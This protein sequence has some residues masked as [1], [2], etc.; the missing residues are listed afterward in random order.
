MKDPVISVAVIVKF[1]AAAADPDAGRSAPPPV[2]V[3]LSFLPSGGATAA[4][5]KGVGVVTG[6]VRD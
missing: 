6:G 5:G 4:Q 1:H 3:F 2:R